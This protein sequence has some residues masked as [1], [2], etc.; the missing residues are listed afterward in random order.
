MNQQKDEGWCAL[1]NRKYRGVLE[2]RELGGQETLGDQS[3]KELRLGQ[4]EECMGK[5]KMCVSP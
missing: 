3:R 5:K 2:Q 1:K 4:N